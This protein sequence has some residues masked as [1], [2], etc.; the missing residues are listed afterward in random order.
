M[1][2]SYSFSP[3]GACMA[4]S[5]QLYFLLVHGYDRFH[6]F[7]CALILSFHSS[8]STVQKYSMVI[9]KQDEIE[10]PVRSD[11]LINVAVNIGRLK[12]S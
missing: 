3:F 8:T 4:V 5:E 10:S 6:S 12:L 2:R 9:N 11:I 1:R 7:H